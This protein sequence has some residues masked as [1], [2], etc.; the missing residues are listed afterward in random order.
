VCIQVTELIAI[1][2]DM[3]FS[4]QCPRCWNYHN[5]E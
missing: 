4:G 5:K 3:K 1:V 2:N